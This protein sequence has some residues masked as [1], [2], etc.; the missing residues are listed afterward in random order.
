MAENMTPETVWY[1]KE[2]MRRS[3]K[4]FAE[5]NT[6]SHDQVKDMLKARRNENKVVAACV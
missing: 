2:M 1:L 6:Y 5:G 3:E 4:D